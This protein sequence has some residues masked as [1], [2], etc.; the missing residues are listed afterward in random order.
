MYRAVTW[1]VLQRGVDPEDEQAA[2]L[3]ARRV[4]MQV[5]P[6]PADGS[7]FCSVWVDG[8]DATPFLRS[9]EV[10]RAVSLVSRMPGVRRALV[11]LQRQA[12]R[13]VPIVM[14]GR[15]IGTTVLPGAELKVY[16]DASRE[17]RASAKRPSGSR[18]T[19][20]SPP[21]ASLLPMAPSGM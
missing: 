17:E 21:L 8:Q 19:R 11:R 16:L 6:P 13:G 3:L 1:L 5:G 4:D 18:S 20:R 9:P 14:A 10:E 2:S 12:A 15:D 7:E